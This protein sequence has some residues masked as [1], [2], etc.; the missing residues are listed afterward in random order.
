[1]P[2]YQEV[3][4]KLAN[5]QLNKLKS[6]AKNKTEIILR[7]NT[8]NFQDGE[9][10]YELFLTIRQTTKIRNAFDNHMSTDKKL[11]KAE[12]SKIFNQVDLFVLG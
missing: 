12:I 11:S 7:M 2:N 6:P 3:R 4:V 5:T 9:L 10:S 8:K 1:M